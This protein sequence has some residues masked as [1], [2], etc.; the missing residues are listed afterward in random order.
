MPLDELKKKPPIYMD[1]KRAPVV[2]DG[3]LGHEVEDF[4]GERFSVILFTIPKREDIS[5]ETRRN[6]MELGLKV[7]SHQELEKFRKRLA[8]SGESVEGIPMKIGVHARKA[9]KAT[10]FARKFLMKK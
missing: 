4:T 9:T 10:G 6:F 3:N 8:T 1:T 7:P 2:F 5:A